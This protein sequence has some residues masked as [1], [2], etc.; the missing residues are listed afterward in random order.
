[1]YHSLLKNER[2]RGLLTVTAEGGAALALDLISGTATEPLY[3][4]AFNGYYDGGVLENGGVAVKTKTVDGY[5]VCS[6]V[7][8]PLAGLSA[9]YA[10]NTY[11]YVPAMKELNGE[12]SGI[13]FDNGRFNVDSFVTVYWDTL[14][15]KDLVARGAAGGGLS[16]NEEY[17]AEYVGG[18]ALDDG[19]LFAAV[20]GADGRLLQTFCGAQGEFSLNFTAAASAAEVKVMLWKSSDTPTPLCGAATERVSD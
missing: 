17:T 4:L 2:G 14:T 10:T 15:K 9:E 19:R 13:V 3:L 12:L 8:F 11:L 1:V 18:E 5:A 16:P 20:Y 7:A 6:Q